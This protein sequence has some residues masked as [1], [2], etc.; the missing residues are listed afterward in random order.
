MPQDTVKKEKLLVKNYP[1]V[2]ENTNSFCSDGEYLLS[3]ILSLISKKAV[4][5][6]MKSQE[7]TCLANS[8][9]LENSHGGV[10]LQPGFVCT[11][12]PMLPMFILDHC[13]FVVDLH[14]QTKHLLHTWGGGICVI[15][16]DVNMHNCK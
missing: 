11:H 1:A 7:K 4:L 9:H 5:Y 15:E 10:V 6:K 12:Q 2:S 14:M 13:R 16:D 3:A 8:L